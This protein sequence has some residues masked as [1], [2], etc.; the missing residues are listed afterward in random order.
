MAQPQSSGQPWP[1]P[2]AV[3]PHLLTVSEEFGY[4]D[5][6]VVTG[7]MPITEPFTAEIDLAAALS[8]HHRD[9]PDLFAT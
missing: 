2:P 4:A 8:P 7:R 5:G 3:D 9:N 1:T 6:G